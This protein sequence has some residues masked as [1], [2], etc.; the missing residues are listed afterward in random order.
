MVSVRQAISESSTVTHMYCASAV[1]RC[2]NDVGQAQYFLTTKHVFWLFPGAR[3]S[4]A[5]AGPSS[6]GKAGFGGGA[7]ASA[8]GQLWVEKHKPT[9]SS[10]LVGN[11][12][13]V[14]TLRTFLHEWYGSCSYSNTGGHKTM[15][16]GFCNGNA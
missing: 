10:E 15:D 12:T 3:S 2:L 6:S 4:G 1:G 11:N 13:L 9:T 7:G 5:S 14:A 8:G 16:S